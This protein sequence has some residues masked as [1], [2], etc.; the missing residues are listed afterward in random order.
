[1]RSTPPRPSN[2]AS[3][4]LAL[5]AL[6]AQG[7]YFDGISARPVQVSVCLADGLLAARGSALFRDWSLR[8]LTLD[9]DGGLVVRIGPAGT[10]ER[11]EIADDAFAA[12]F[13]ARNP[14][15]R[16]GRADRSDALRILGLSCL[17]LAML[18]GVAIWGVPY[19]ADRLAPML[20]VS[21]EA[22]LGDIAEKQLDIIVGKGTTCNSPAA[23]RAMEQLVSELAPDLSPAPR[24]GIRLSAQANALALPGGRIVVLSRL[25]T[26]ARTPDEFAAILAHELGHV[27]SRDPTRE[28]IR[29]AGNALLLTY[30]M[31]SAMDATLTAAIANGLIAAS[32]SRDAEWAADRYAVAAVSRVGGDGAALAAIL[33]RIDSEGETPMTFMRTHPFARERASSIRALAA[34][35]PKPVER[36]PLLDPLSWAAI[37]AACTPIESL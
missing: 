31:G 11:I 16:R 37:K 28:V 17:V 15:I 10:A 24:V 3:E 35:E 21:I 34:R 25:V 22:H 30:V 13:R 5:S 12:A 32:Y 7:R 6:D 19:L 4:A 14:R 33:E 1:M 2:S 36:K 26:E 18:L 20:P 9:D 27:A 29:G 8:D 23:Q